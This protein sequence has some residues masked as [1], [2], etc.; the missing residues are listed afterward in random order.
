MNHLQLNKM[1]LSFSHTAPPGNA[2][3]LYTIVRTKWPCTSCHH[4]IKEELFKN[5]QVNKQETRITS[6]VGQTWRQF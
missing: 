3:P 5:G 2:Q 4:E 6:D 1:I